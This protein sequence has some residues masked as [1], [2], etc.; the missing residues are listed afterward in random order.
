MSKAVFE[1]DGNGFTSKRV[2]YGEGACPLRV[3]LGVWRSVVGSASGVWDG[4]PAENEFSLISC[5]FLSSGAGIS[6]IFDA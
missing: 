2:E 1:G 3:R 5:C 4:A 6:A